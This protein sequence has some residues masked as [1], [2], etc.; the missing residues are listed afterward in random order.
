MNFISLYTFIQELFYD[1]NLG[2]AVTTV[3]SPWQRSDVTLTQIQYY[4]VKAVRYENSDSSRQRIISISGLE[5]FMQYKLHSKG[6]SNTVQAIMLLS[7]DIRVGCFLLDYISPSSV[8]SKVDDFATF[9]KVE[10]HAKNSTF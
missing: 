5:I 7:H 8:L 4:I 1:N 10:V 6:N 3:T 9:K 2:D